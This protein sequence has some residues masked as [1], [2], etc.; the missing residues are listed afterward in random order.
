MYDFSLKPELEK[1]AKQLGIQAG[2][3][4]AVSGEKAIKAKKQLA[5]L[6]KLDF[7]NLAFDT[8]VAK[9]YTYV[10][11]DLHSLVFSPNRTKAYANFQR[12][13]DISRKAKSK[14][15]VSMRAQDQ[16]QLRTERDIRSFLIVL[17]LTQE[18]A[19]AAAKGNADEL[20][21]ECLKKKIREGVEY[22]E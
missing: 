20:A 11:F 15:L 12:A 2:R 4:P 17:G 13:L 14:I 8:V 21:K 16:Y 9:Q 6:L 7:E 3:C 10:E 1:E 5:P 22:E 18:E 19:K